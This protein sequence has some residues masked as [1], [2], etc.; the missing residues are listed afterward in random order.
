MRF[1]V[2]ANKTQLRSAVNCNSVRETK[3]WQLILGGG[4]F[5]RKQINNPGH[6]GISDLRIT[7]VEIL[8]YKLSH[9]QEM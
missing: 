2:K 1:W 9:T 5:Y 4:K 6:C 8:L 3:E 7:H